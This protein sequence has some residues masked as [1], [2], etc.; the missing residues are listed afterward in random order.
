MEKIVWV[1]IFS[2]WT[3]AMV[4][5]RTEN[6]FWANYKDQSHINLCSPPRT[7]LLFLRVFNQNKNILTN[8]RKHFKQQISQKS[9]HWVSDCSMETDRR[10]ERHD[11]ANSDCFQL[12][13]AYSC[14]EKSNEIPIQIHSEFRM[15]CVS[16]ITDQLNSWNWTQRGFISKKLRVWIIYK[17]IY[18]D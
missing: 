7:R 16:R 12:E 3:L 9:V 14:M 2:L 8:V 4:S 1:V 13:C 11:G 5:H 18:S 15:K 10:T 6:I 17:E